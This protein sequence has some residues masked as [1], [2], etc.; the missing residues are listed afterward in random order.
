LAIVGAFMGLILGWFGGGSIGAVLGAIVLGAGGYALG[1][2]LAPASLPKPDDRLAKIQFLLNQ[3]LERFGATSVAELRRRQTRYL[4]LRAVVPPAR[5]R[6]R[7]QTDW[8]VRHQ[9]ALDSLFLV[10]GTRDVDAARAAEAALRECERAINLST[11]QLG[12]AEVVRDAALRNLGIRRDAAVRG[13][14]VVGVTATEPEVAFASLRALRETRL[15]RQ[16]LLS[17]K[18]EHR[19]Q[20][21]AIAGH[22]GALAD[23]ERKLVQARAIATECL[24]R[25][26]IAS[27]DEESSDR[28]R[29]RREA[30]RAY[31]DALVRQSELRN[32]RRLVIGSDDP[33]EWIRR[34]DVLLSQVATTDECDSRGVEEL[35]RLIEEARRLRDTAFHTRSQVRANRDST[36]QG[37]RPPAE[38]EEDLSVA[39]RERDRLERL[40]NALEGANSLLAEVAVNFRRGFAPRLENGVRETL[41]TVTGGRYQ[42][43]AID[44]QDLE[45]KLKLAG[46]VDLVPF[47][48]VSHGTRDAVALLLR[49]SIVD[50]L[51]NSNEPA[52]IFLDDPLVHIDRQRATCLLETLSHLAEQ[53]QLFYFTQ[54]ERVIDW[55]ENHSGCSVHPLDVITA[56]STP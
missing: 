3:E 10:G 39:T 2:L 44:P 24:A 4:E 23:A 43:V 33:V 19:H 16:E 14:A 50:L 51:T 53:R 46:Q 52:P 17:A 28:L 21:D 5:E 11:T 27:L 1:R 22:A 31:S 29:I 12:D 41:T 36:I 18:A 49:T 25:V 8:L 26:G 42:D 32:S 9:V 47:H 34:R 30:F 37:V 48:R 7:A 56:R 38:I 6:Q 20:A 40:K 55:A 45:I 35:G 54:D 13:L 15:Q